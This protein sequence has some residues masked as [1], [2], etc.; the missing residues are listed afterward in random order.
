MEIVY[1]LFFIIC[2]ILFAIGFYNIGRRKTVQEKEINYQKELKQKEKIELDLENKKQQLQ[3]IEK[4]YADKQK[5]ISHS[6]SL[7]EEVYHNKFAL[8]EEKY[9]NLEKEKQR[10]YSDICE[11][12]QNQYKE[13]VDKQNKEKEI[14]CNELKS[15]QSTRAAAIKAF[16]LE[17]MSQEERN[18]FRLDVSDSDLNDVKILE[19]VRPRLNKPRVLSMLIWQTFYQPLAKKK[20]PA[21]LGDKPIC[22]IYKIT[23]LKDEKIYVGQAKDCRKRWLDHCKHGLG[24]DTP[25]TNKLY[26]AMLQDGLE[27]FTFELLEECSEDQLDK[28]EQYF[29]EMFSSVEWGYNSRKQIG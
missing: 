14:I 4:E 11:K 19:T 5:L 1:F 29:I 13:W 6:E 15:I 18:Q 27:N 28:N 9:E 8:L 2:I 3:Q 22:G 24:I 25:S 17:A 7:A 26:Q 16:Q 20:F 21:I 12:L 10:K 23:N